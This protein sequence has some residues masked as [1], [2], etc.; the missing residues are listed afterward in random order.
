[1]CYHSVSSVSRC[2]FYL[3]SFQNSLSSWKFCLQ[4]LTNYQMFNFFLHQSQ[5]YCHYACS[6]PS[7]MV[8]V[9]ESSL[10]LSTFCQSQN[11]AT[12]QKEVQVKWNYKMLIICPSWL[13]MKSRE[14]KS[15]EIRVHAQGCVTAMVLPG[16]SLIWKQICLLLTLAPERKIHLI[17]PNDLSSFKFD[18]KFFF[19][20]V[21]AYGENSWGQK[22]Q[23]NVQSSSINQ[24]LPDWE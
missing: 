12:G 10:L 19:I 3:S 16:L 18:L 9:L 13:S 1:M 8:C 22:R 11:F 23:T 21:H 7:L 4:L 2:Q 14:P 20:S 6:T 17:S 5:H 24:M 15:Q